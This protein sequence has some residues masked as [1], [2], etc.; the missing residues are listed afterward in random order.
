MTLFQ[1]LHKAGRVLQKCIGRF[2]NYELGPWMSGGTRNFVSQMR[3]R[4][5][6]FVIGR[7]LGIIY[8]I[9]L[10][11]R[12]RRPWFTLIWWII[13]DRSRMAVCKKS[14]GVVYVIHRARAVSCSV[15]AG[16]RYALLG[17]RHDFVVICGVFCVGPRWLFRCLVWQVIRIQN[18]LVGLSQIRWVNSSL[19]GQ[20][21]LLRI[22]RIVS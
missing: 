8:E 5:L 12:I 9:S 15:F 16:I 22:L 19:I 21:L 14:F 20:I 6:S 18:F 2:R 11:F 3:G 10:I 13:N 1:L 7:S 4:L 17:I